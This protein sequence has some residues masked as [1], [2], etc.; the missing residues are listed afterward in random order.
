MQNDILCEIDSKQAVI[1]LLLDLSAA[2]DNVE[3][4]TLLTGLSAMLGVKT[5]ALAWCRSYLTSNKQYNCVES[6]KSSR[7]L[8]R[9]VPHGYVL[10]PLLYLIFTSP[11]GKIIKRHGIQCHLY[12]D[13]S[14]LRLV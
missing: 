5:T 9:G 11:I 10:G 2:F 4:S 6:S 3:H 1:L 14:Q 8:D 13:D 12:A 7:P